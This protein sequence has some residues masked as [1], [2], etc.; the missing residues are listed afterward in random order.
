MRKPPDLPKLIAGIRA[1]DRASLAQAI[2]LVE[3]R[4]P[5]HR[6]PARELMQAIL[7]N[8]GG[9]LRVGL[10]GTP[11][12]GKSTFIE[13]LGMM[14]C[15]RGKKVAVLAVDPSSSRT[16]GS[17]LGDK[18]R[19]EDLARHENAFIRPSPSG[20][21]LGGVAARTREALLLCEAAGYDVILVET[22]GVGQSETAVRTMTDFFL[23]LQI[24]GAGDELQGIKKGVIELADAIV[25]NK[26]DGD[27]KMRAK[28]AKVEYTKV[29]HF[30]HPFTP[31]WKPKALTCSALNCEG[32]ERVWQLI[33]GFRDQLTESG[34]FEARRR[35]QNVDWFDSLLQSIVMERYRAEHGQQIQRMATA[36]KDGQMPVSVALDALLGD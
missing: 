36:V 24:A 16:G 28:L 20:N 35:E 22:V 12:A 19:M 33:E 11:G 10:T 3:S 8:T 9:A 27:N 23:L 21:S 34:V 31:G 32:I 29:L 18:T 26:A 14:L 4:A 2:T 5:K 17:I 30:L 25:V 7:P 1:S 6:A 13:A 15:G